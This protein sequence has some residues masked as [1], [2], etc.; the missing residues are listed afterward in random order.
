MTEQTRRHLWFGAAQ[1]AALSGTVGAVLNIN[2]AVPTFVLLSSLVIVGTSVTGF[3]LSRER[4]ISVARFMLLSLATTA[5]GSLGWLIAAFVVALFTSYMA[6]SFGILLAP[7][8]GLY[9]AFTLAIF[10]LSPFQA[11]QDGT[12]DHAIGEVRR[13]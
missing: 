9:S 6:F 7:I 3:V 1:L 12:I 4:G 11:S 10:G 2:T 13:D 5:V 8:L